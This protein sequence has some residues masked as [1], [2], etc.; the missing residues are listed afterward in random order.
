MTD[1]RLPLAELLQKAGD[2][3]FLRSVAEAVVQLLMENDVEG[4]IGAGRHERTAERATYRNGYRDRT[5]DTRLGSLQL[6]IPKLRQGSYFPPFLEPRKTTEKALVAVIQEA[7]IGGV[8]TRKVDD[9][10]QAMG[11]TGISKSTVS[12]LCKDIDD[13]V[14]AFLERPLVGDWP[15]LWLDATYLKQREGGRIVSVAA[16]IAVAVDSEGKREIVGLHIGPSEAET[17]WS[18]FLK[19][20]V[21]RGLRGTKLVI[22]DAHEGLKAAIRR[23]MGA[24]W[25]RCR[26][27]WMRNALAYVPK[28]QQSMVSASLR[29]AFLQDTPEKAHAVWRAAADGMR[30]RWPKL[31]V[32]MD[33]SE[34]DVLAY[35]A[36]PE[37]HRAKLHSTNPLERLN[38]EVKRRADVVGIFPSE[39]SILRLIGAVLLEQNDEWQLQHRYM[40]VEGMAG[41]TPP[42]IDGEATSLPSDQI[43]PKAA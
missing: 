23:V 40:Q 22:S 30:Q 35:M 10:V 25:Q 39:Q 2:D 5:L 43:P 18:T 16:I 3:D 11:L 38:K 9:L 6:R 19:S 24:T 42:T 1:D 32:F 29:Q 15:Y 8:S 27:H 33:D 28:S 34:H 13:R 26:V 17:F 21:R 41:L 7:W 4:L 36:F 31:G 37:Q 14:G 20:L 12:K